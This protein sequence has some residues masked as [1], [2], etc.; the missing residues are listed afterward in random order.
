M[1][2]TFYLLLKIIIGSFM[3]LGL[4]G[5][6][7]KL[8][9]DNIAIVMGIGIDK[10]KEMDE[11][12]MTVQVA[13]PA[14]IKSASTDITGSRTTNAYFNLE[15]TGDT[16]FSTLGS[17]S[18]QSS[19]KLFFAQNQVLILGR[20]IAEEG[21]E[22]YIDFFLRDRETRL[23]VWVLVSDK[24]ANEIL[25]VK[26]DFES[27]PSRSI[28]E[29]VKEQQFNSE[30]PMIDLREFASRLMSKT[31][32]PIAPIIKVSMAGNKKIPSISGTGIFKKNKMVGEMKKTETRGMLWVL[33]EVKKGSI[34]VNDPGTNNKVTL[35]ITRASSKIIPEMEDGKVYIKIVIKEEGNLGDQSDSN[36]LT[37]PKVL[38]ALEK[39]KASK[40][41]S[42]VMSSLKKAQSLHADV[43]G[44]GDA[45]YKK[46]PNKWKFMEDD[47][48]EIFENI[49]VDVVV[50]AKLRRSGRI[51]KP[52][53]SK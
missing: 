2:K 42:E 10:A 53:T 30:A 29:L 50:D 44:F 41:K 46:Y 11:V 21:L 25:N 35:D 26:S 9:L 13:N 5:C 32:S 43:F 19:R 1:K 14:E 8:E 24:T 16:I 37:K 22:K 33:G 4:T 18:K 23:L 51:T 7:D 40:I 45:I 47:W 34:V 38:E 6:W 17:F 28:N 27:I 36:D 15:R 31:T 20:E 3:V 52:I 49:R 48:D 39:E 12:R